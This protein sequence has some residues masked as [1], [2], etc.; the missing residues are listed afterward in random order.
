MHEYV[1]LLSKSRRYFYDKS[2]CPDAH[3]SVWDIAPARGT[4]E[5]TAVFPDELVERCLLLTSRPGDLVADPFMGSGTVG[6][7]A[8][9]LGREWVGVEG[10]EWA[11]TR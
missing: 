1:F 11:P 10:R 5:H 8:E 7:V 6:R 2:A 3:T 9:S 4:T